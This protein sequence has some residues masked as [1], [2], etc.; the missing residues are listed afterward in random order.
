MLWASDRPDGG[1]GLNLLGKVGTVVARSKMGCYDSCLA[2]DLE[3]TILDE[4]NIRRK[5]VSPLIIHPE[6]TFRKYWDIGSVFL[7]LYSCITVPY[8]LA[9][10]T[11]PRGF[12]AVVDKIVDLMFMLD[13]VLNFFTARVHIED[14]GPEL[15]TDFGS[16]AVLYLKGWFL[17]DLLSSFPFDAVVAMFVDDTNPEALR[18]AK[19]GRML[20]MMKILRMVR[21]KRLLSKL[22]YAMGLKNGAVDIVQFFLF[23]VFAAHFNACMFYVKGEKM[24]PITWSRAYCV[25]N[26]ITG[27]EWDEYYLLE[28]PTLLEGT[29]FID[30]SANGS[31]PFNLGND[32]CDPET[33]IQFC[34]DQDIPSFNADPSG[35]ECD[36]EIC[37][38]K[39]SRYWSAFYWSI[40]TMTTVGYGDIL[41]AT[42]PE[43]YYCLF[44]MGVS[45]VIFAFAMT[46]ICTF[47][48]NLNRNEVYKQNRFDELIGYM[49]TCKVTK[50]FHRRAIEYF[51]FKTGDKCMAAFYAMDTITTE[52]FGTNTALDVF[53]TIYSP[54]VRRVPLLH[55]VNLLLF[56]E[57]S[58]HLQLHVYGPK[59]TICVANMFG[60]GADMQIV[61][62]GK[63]GIV[64]PET[65]ELIEGHNVYGTHALFGMMEYP[66]NV[67]AT[68][69]C[70][71]YTLSAI[72]FKDCLGKHQLNILQLECDLR[73]RGTWSDT[74]AYLCKYDDWQPIVAE[75]LPEGEQESDA[76][77]PTCSPGLGDWEPGTFDDLSKTNVLTAKYSSDAEE[78]VALQTF[79]RR[80]R[81]YIGKLLL[82]K[83]A[84]GTAKIQCVSTTAMMARLRESD[85]LGGDE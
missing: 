42:D 26:P 37:A 67:I 41:P 70:D 84:N 35:C 22:Q 24:E 12:V 13:I 83:R 11:E 85:E 75:G 34:Y 21:I 46:S 31:N 58:R 69:F 82:T 52:E 54:F 6:A 50:S 45:A 33:E 71:I 55:S 14:D 65:Q 76:D 16:I 25:Q 20:R 2:P 78:V 15:K 9:L 53:E 51:G 74:H 3:R 36:P 62:Q 49:D 28:A 81:A 18:M 10:G 66:S 5:S 48:I 43:R 73:V 17:P 38:E 30:F 63:I 1:L 64:H 39:P 57:I 47:I 29:H 56:R 7:I 79:E 32:Q 23:I 40:V 77:Y 44:A 59:D 4:W 80:Q 27:A 72:V 60:A 19:L 61:A 8:F 68:D